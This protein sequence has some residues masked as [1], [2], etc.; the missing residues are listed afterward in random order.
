M[1]GW[2]GAKVSGTSDPRD[3]LSYVSTDS[4]YLA[5]WGFV[6]VTSNLTAVE[7]YCSKVALSQSQHFAQASYSL[8]KLPIWVWHMELVAWEAPY[9]SSELVSSDST[10][11]AASPGRRTRQQT[12]NGWGA[13]YALYR[14]RRVL[15]CMDIS[16]VLSFRSGRKLT[17]PQYRSEASS[18]QYHRSHGRTWASRCALAYRSS[19]QHGASS[20]LDRLF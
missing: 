6:D 15:W 13:R 11:A 9:W 8:E 3:F 5:N 16:Y 2:R 14:Q 7:S 17:S 20:S 19:A 1:E 18:K 10:Q 4:R 12:A